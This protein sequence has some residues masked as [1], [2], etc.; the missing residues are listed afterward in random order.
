MKPSLATRTHKDYN[1]NDLSLSTVLKVPR[2]ESL[3]GAGNE[4]GMVGNIMFDRGNQELYYHNGDQWIAMGLGGVNGNYADFFALMPSDNSSTVA[5]G[6]AVQFPQNGPTSGTTITRLSAS[7]FNL[8][9]IGTYHVTFQVSIT[10]GANAAQL[11]VKIGSTAQ[12][13]TVVGRATG[14]DQLYG[15][16]LIT[17]VAINSVLSIINPLGNATALTITTNAGGTHA[18]SARLVIEQVA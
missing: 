2:N 14:I 3:A 9:A 13:N 8:A 6:A 4:P 17:T 5:L 1:Q 15:T 12:P 7:T 16:C 10:E 11:Q 18:V